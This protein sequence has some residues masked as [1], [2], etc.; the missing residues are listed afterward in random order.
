M[1]VVERAIAAVAGRQDNVV[2]LEQLIEAGLGRGAITH[3]L[4]ARIIRRIHRTVYL[5]GAAPPTPV[6]RARA[7]VLAVGD[8]AVLSHR[9]AAELFAL[10]PEAGGDVDVTII[11]RNPGVHP[12]IRVHRPRALAPV[13]VT[14]VRRMSVTSVA[15]TIC[16]VAA[17]E[18]RDDVMR[19]PGG[20]LSARCHASRPRRGAGARAEA[21]GC[22]RHPRTHRRPAPDAFR[23][24]TTLVEADRSGPA[25]AP[26]NQRADSGHSGRCPLV[27]GETDRRVRRMGGHTAT[28]SR[29]RRTASATRYWW[30]PDT[31]FY[32]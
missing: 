9:S 3:R 30:P 24:G 16:D 13:D 2:T 6:A 14:T 23:A 20:A 26:A 8:G 31:A 17:T 4:Q 7:A 1:Q 18:S 5:M 22:A 29:S 10:L 32:A 11:G 28:G 21:Q 19:L 15:R 12:G 25:A 27:R